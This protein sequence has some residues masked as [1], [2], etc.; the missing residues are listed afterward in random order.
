[1]DS[2]LEKQTA[3][4]LSNQ[5]DLLQPD[6]EVAPGKIRDLLKKKVQ[7]WLMSD[8]ERLVNAMYR[9][10]IPEAKFHE[11]MGLQDPEKIA[12]RIAD[13]IWEREMQ[14]AWYRQKYS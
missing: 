3:I 9:L 4:A 1:M 13:L 2:D 7:E 8:F 10:D 5:W 12:P 11:A 14:R 6:P